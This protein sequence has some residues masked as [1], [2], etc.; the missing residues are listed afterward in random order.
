MD[1]NDFPVF[2]MIKGKLNWLAERQRVLA[3]NVANA[4]TPN[5]RPSD[6]KEVDFRNPTAGDRFAVTLA[7]THPSHRALSG[8]AGQHRAEHQ[9]DTYETVPSGNAVVLEEQLV[10]VAKNQGDYALITQLYRK[11]L[12]MFRIALGRQSR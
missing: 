2:R 12:Q 3:A 7:R 4:D 9:R 6:L 10:K 5:Y 8:A 11:H 1:M